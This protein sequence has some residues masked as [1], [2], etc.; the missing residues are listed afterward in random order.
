MGNFYKC[1][2]KTAHPHYVSWSAIDGDKPDFHRP[3][4]FGKLWFKKTEPKVEDQQ[5]IKQNLQPNGLKKLLRK[6]FGK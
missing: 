5:V 3:D 4:C 6:I 2:S 1:G